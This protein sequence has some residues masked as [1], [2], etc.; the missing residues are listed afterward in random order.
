MT[1]SAST[2]NLPRTPRRR[3]PGAL[4]IAAIWILVGIG[5]FLLIPCSPISLFREYCASNIGHPAAATE[6]PAAATAAA[7]IVARTASGAT[8]I[9][10]HAGWCGPCHRLAPVVD[11]VLRGRPE[12]ALWRIDIDAERSLA[13]DA[14]VRS[15]PALHLWRDGRELDRRLG[16]ADAATIREWIDAALARTP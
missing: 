12:V 14:G 1:A 7:T 3:A 16:A 6:T 11:E 8:L 9:V 15:I 2:G 5:T 10:F 4:A 13:E